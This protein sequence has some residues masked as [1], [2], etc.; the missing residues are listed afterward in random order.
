MHTRVS[1]PAVH[2]LSLFSWPLLMVRGIAALL[3]VLSALLA[4]DKTMTLLAWFFA[5]YVFF[6]GAYSFVGLVSA[7]DGGVLHRVLIGCKSIVGVAAGVAVILLAQ[8]G[9]TLVPMLFTVFAWVAIVGILEGVWVIR[10]VRNQ[11]MVLIIGSSAYLALAL[12]LQ[13]IF[14]LAPNAGSAVY[15][16]I[17]IGFSA[18]FAAAMFGMSWSLRLQQRRQMDTVS[19]SVSHVRS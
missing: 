6:D 2:Q 5:V 3:F 7:Q 16:W 4:F 14:A 11:E 8:K 1:V 9:H 15:N 18:A 17:I 10:S 19:H 12:A 13:F